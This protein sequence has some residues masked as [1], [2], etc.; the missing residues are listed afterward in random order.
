MKE[1]FFPEKV[2]YADIS[3]IIN[4]NPDIDTLSVEN[5][6]Q[7]GPVLDDTIR[8]NEEELLQSL[9]FI[10]FPNGKKNNLYAF[11]QKLITGKSQGQLV[12]IMHY[13]DSQIEGDRITSFVRAKLQYAFGGYGVGL[14]PVI[15]VAPSFSYDKEVSSNWKRY[16]G[17]GKKDPKILHNRYGVLASFC[18]Y[19]PIQ[20]DSVFND[21]LVY[22]AWI[23]L[24]SSKRAYGPSKR[25]EQCC[26]FYGNNKK[27]VFLDI[28]KKRHFKIKPTFC[29]L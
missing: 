15:D 24:G 29:F 21:S 8:I 25:F 12:R 6:L 1:L 22:K 18:R 27:D 28:Y 14:F 16:P 4:T 11:F 9:Q 20:N 26:I 17:F 3:D 2:E 5:N 10:E 13:G 23:K 7:D 19:A